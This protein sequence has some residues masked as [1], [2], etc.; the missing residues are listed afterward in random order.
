MMNNS[1]GIP[2][3][4]MKVKSQYA[5]HQ[6]FLKC[7]E[8]NPFLQQVVNPNGCKKYQVLEIPGQ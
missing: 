4:M 3:N 6:S 5:E 7:L 2:Q 1:V 8:E